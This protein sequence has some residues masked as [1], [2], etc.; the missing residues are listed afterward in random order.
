MISHSLGLFLIVLSPWLLLSG[1]GRSS[2]S[3]EVENSELRTFTLS[4][5]QPKEGS[6]AWEA[7]KVDM[8]I[9]DSMRPSL[10]FRKEKSEFRNGLS[11]DFELRVQQGK[12]KIELAYFGSNQ[13]KLY[14]SCLEARAYIHS[15]FTNDYK[16]KIAVCPVGQSTPVGEVQ[17]SDLSDVHLIPELQGSQEKPQSEVVTD[18]LKAN[19][20]LPT[21]NIPSRGEGIPYADQKIDLRLPSLRIDASNKEIKTFVAQV[22]DA[23]PTFRRVYEG[24][25][26]LTRQ[27]ALAFMFADMSR[28]S[29]QGERWRIDL[30]TGVGG[31]GHAWG[32]F[33]AAVTNFKGSAFEK[34]LGLYHHTGLPILDMSQ[35]KDPASSTYMGMKRLA[36]GVLRSIKDPKIG[37]GRSA[38][39][40]LLGTLADHNTGWPSS[41]LDAAWQRDYGL[42]VLRLMQAYQFG[43]N[44]TNDRAF[45]TTQPTEQIC[46]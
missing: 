4:Q 11:E 34:D 32:P 15:I 23:V 9:V 2:R 37:L 17:V 12:Y 8:H 22:Y 25:L 19:Y 10:S 6:P 7:M 40:Y 14:E 20:G 39:D 13:E 3:I 1:C 38:K 44:M 43:E 42:E 26:G 27:Q 16:A 24:E 29:A 46:K 31:P 28:E 41:A 21:A 18:C 5:F 33:Q 36:D 45:W 35:F 30:E